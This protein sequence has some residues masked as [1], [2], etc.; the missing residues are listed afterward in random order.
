[1]K[2]R[3]KKISASLLA[4]VMVFTFMP[5]FGL[6]SIAYA[7]TRTYTVE[8]S[9]S[10]IPDQTWTGEDI[11]LSQVDELAEIYVRYQTGGSSWNPTYSEP[12]KLTRG[13]DFTV[14]A[15]SNQVGTANAVFTC[16]GSYEGD[17]INSVPF[18]IV[19]PAGEPAEYTATLN[20][21][22]FVYGCAVPT[23]SNVS[24][25]V[26][27]I[28]NGNTKLS[29][30]STRSEGKYFV[31]V[32]EAS[33][34]TTHN[35]SAGEQYI[36]TAKV[37]GAKE[38]EDIEVASWTVTIAKKDLADVT[39][40]ATIAAFTYDSKEKKP[41]P[42]KVSVGTDEL[43]ATTDYTIAGYENNVNASDEAYV[44]VQ[45]TDACKN[46]TGT[47]KAAFTI[48]PFVISDSMKL[49]VNDAKTYTY[50]GTVQKPEVSTTL[51]FE[52]K[53]GATVVPAADYV[54]EYPDSDYTNVGQKNVTIKASGNGNLVENTTAPTAPTAKGFAITKANLAD[55][56]VDQVN[57]VYDD[58]NVVAG[59]TSFFDVTFGEVPVDGSQYDIAITPATPNTVGTVKTVKLTAKTGDSINYTGSKEFTYTVNAKPF[60]KL[61]KSNATSIIYDK[62]EK[63][64]TAGT[65]GTLELVGD[66]TGVAST[67]VANTDYVV[68]ETTFKNNINAG[69][70]TATALITGRGHYAGQSATVEFSIQQQDITGLTVSSVGGVNAGSYYVGAVIEGATAKVGSFDLD[71]DNCVV[72]ASEIPASESKLTKVLVK[73]AGNYK[74]TAAVFTLNPAVNADRVDLRNAVIESDGI[75]AGWDKANYDE[76][77]VAD[78]IKVKVGNTVIGK[79]AYTLTI[80]SDKTAATY[81][82]LDST[83]NFTITG[84]D[85]VG[86]K[87]SKNG[88]ITVVKRSIDA[89]DVTVTLSNTTYEYNGTAREPNV[90][91]KAAHTTGNLVKDTD[92]TVTYADN[93]DAGEATVTVE[94]IGNYKNSV[95]KTFSITK[96]DPAKVNFVLKAVDASKRQFKVGVPED[97]SEELELVAPTGTSYVVNPTADYKFKQQANPVHEGHQSQTGSG[98][99]TTYDYDFVTN[100]KAK[101]EATDAVRA[102]Y[103]RG[104]GWNTQTVTVDNI[105]VYY[106]ATFKDSKNYKD[107]SVDVYYVM[108]TRTASDADVN[109]EHEVVEYKA[110]AIS[111][112]QSDLG[113]IE[114][115][116]DGNVLRSTSDYTI[117]LG[118]VNEVGENGFVEV[119][120]RGNYSGKAKKAFTIVEERFD[121][122]NVKLVKPT[123]ANSV[124]KEGRPISVKAN[125]IGDKYT[126][127][128]AADRFDVVYKDS[129]GNVLTGAP[130]EV[131][132][133]TAT[134][135][136]KEQYGGE[137]GETVEFTVDQKKL[138]SVEFKNRVNTLSVGTVPYYGKLTETPELSGTYADEFEVVDMTTTWDGT[139]ADKGKLTVILKSDSNYVYDGSGVVEFSWT[140]GNLANIDVNDFF[141]IPD[142]EYTGAAVEPWVETVYGSD[143][144]DSWITK[145]VY[146]NNVAK[147]AM[148]AHATITLVAP[149]DS[150]FYTGTVTG[151]IAFGIVTPEEAEEA[152]DA[153]LT[154][155]AGIDATYPAA[156]KKAVDDAAATLKDLLDGNGTT[157]QIT[158]ATARLNKAILNAEIA[159][160]NA[161]IAE[162]DKY[163]TAVYT[164]D[165]VSAIAAAKKAVKDAIATGDAAKIKE[166]NAKLEAAVKAA[167]KKVANGLTVSKKTKKVKASKLKKKSKKVTAITVSNAT[168][169]VTYSGKGVNKKSKKALKVLSNGKIKVKKG[170]KKGTY[171]IKVTV[172][173]A[174]DG[175]TLAAT[176][177]V[178]VKIKVK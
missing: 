105:R 21:S 36:I 154:A 45:A 84:K 110:G 26:K 40:T 112:Y 87:E 157:N 46:Y 62:T 92:F 80:T 4:A 37:W 111:G 13:E 160:A 90:T 172:K 58:S 83:I 145:V 170:T 20:D 60:G 1:M 168:G 75:P 132:S 126:D 50:T 116:V 64:P 28:A 146:D 77:A 150:L 35:A 67:L 76:D 2:D 71:A 163:T 94:G 29:Y 141:Y 34:N 14:E 171:K 69:E 31:T 153:A 129:E 51:Y 8:D 68:D 86:T 59:F 104:S 122:E 5:V 131:G 142:Q 16:I 24:S 3:I 119:D 118:G 175:N 93:T 81:G 136:A 128:Q 125:Y 70:L 99:G 15:D 121:I 107:G 57:T 85:S 114:V 48:N 127:A 178:K 66:E 169:K 161:T 144:P 97:L 65:L 12:F 158:T 49:V 18:N 96:V 148:S 91:V 100:V 33:T 17:T 147:S 72:E 162:A 156:E 47:G 9:A 61:Y 103:R 53:V 138:T 7:E 166:A 137:T 133:Y 140:K 63:R 79:G 152:A 124:Y 130:T 43:L 167:A 149:D 10:L 109:L 106:T 95:R 155:A 78:H 41:E 139:I 177:T 74:G 176:K 123:E 30:S 32:A 108:A 23:A 22:G 98:W 6:G 55:V 38:A 151:T 19:E 56:S 173:A 52:D 88:S 44:L 143:I 89:A 39:V 174:G 42:A 120:F 101:V 117:S 102:T 73:G 165:S 115:K 164:N 134:A 25:K 159:K 113:K 82:T 11:D 54:I 135:V 27:V